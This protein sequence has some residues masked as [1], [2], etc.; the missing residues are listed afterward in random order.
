MK[1]E[2][3]NTFG[4]GLIMDLNPMTTPNNVLT[5]CL[6]GTVVTYNGNE[7]VL[8][9]DMG[10]GEVGTARL[11]VG[12][13]PVGM[14][15]HGGIIYVAAHNPVTGKSQIGS[16]PSP[17]QL[18]EGEDINVAAINIRFNE[19]IPVK[20]GVPYIEV[21]YY[22]RRLF[23][24]MTTGEP[25]KFHP[26]DK[27]I[28]VSDVLGSAL[29]NAINAGVVK[30]RLGVIN[31]SGVI[32]YIDDKALKTY[33]NGLWIYENSNTPMIDVLKS[34]ELVQVF[35]SKSSGALVLVIEIES[36][37]TFNLLRKYS[38]G[39][40]TK[41]IKVE[42][43]GEMT[44]H[45]EGKTTVD[46]NVKLYHD[47]VLKDSVLF[48]RPD[49][50]NEVVEY[51]VAPACPYG[52]L[53]RMTKSGVLDFAAIRSNKEIFGEWRFF[54]TETYVKIGWGY[55]Y[56][57]LNEDSDVEKVRF[58]FIDVNDSQHAY[59]AD[60][61]SGVWSYDIS[62]EYFNGSFEEIIPFSD[63]TIRKNWIYIVRIGKYVQGVYSIIG[64]RLLYT[65]GYF[66][67]IYETTADF[68]TL[69]ST[70]EALGIES[71]ITSE[72]TGQE[73]DA[74]FLRTNKDGQFVSKTNLRVDDY[75]T[76]VSGLDVDTTNYQYTT[77]KVGT[78]NVKIKPSMEIKYDKKMY[79][80]EPKS[81]ENAFNNAT[82]R[83]VTFDNSGIKYNSTSIL[84]SNISN[85]E[86]QAVDFK[87]DSAQQAIIGKLTTSRSI[88]ANAGGVKANPYSTET[89][90]PLY[91]TTMSSSERDQLF[92]FKED[93]G[94]TYC[95]GGDRGHIF[96]NTRVTGQAHTSG[97]FVGESAGSG[98]DDNGLQA[99]LLAMSNN[100]A[101]GIMAGV[102][103]D[104]ASLRI[105]AAR[106]S[107]NGWSCGD[108]EIDSEDNFMIATWKDT[109]GRHWL[110]NLASR[111]TESNSPDSNRLIRIEKMLK[112]F[113]SQ[114]L[115]VQRG[116]SET[117]FVGPNNLEF[118]YNMPFNTI[119]TTN[120]TPTISTGDRVVDFYLGND[121]T[122]ITTHLNKWKLALG[123]KFVN[124]APTF[125]V[126]IPASFPV[127][128]EYGDTVR[129]DSDSN[130]L[131][132][133]TNAY[134]F[135]SPTESPIDKN[136]IDR[137]RIYIGVTTGNANSDGTMNLDI[138][139]NTG[140]PK[141][142][143]DSYL[144]DWQGRQVSLGYNLNDR[145]ITKYRMEGKSDA[146]DENYFNTVYLRAD[147]LYTVANKWTHNKDR[148]APDMA[149]NIGFGH[150]STSYGKSLYRYS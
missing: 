31:T 50:S 4:D 62:K 121:S 146:I 143:S 10:N 49:S 99:A 13:V 150:P 138:D 88:F 16:F 84:N 131:S 12:Y 123:D 43:I 63:A 25:R 21:E 17:Q 142:H 104:E 83:N 125:R 126:N 23:E 86:S 98:Y 60:T 116:S 75:I 65:S 82:V 46:E 110:I 115:V 29:R 132:C 147:I 37:D 55:D 85:I 44:G 133:Y 141:T 95:A 73:D 78:Y 22:K 122:S 114:M 134:A 93:G 130:I 94:V 7:F 36:F 109:N 149:T 64:Y 101:I 107:V 26:G 135:K 71:N 81:L 67:E 54:V 19:L 33:S 117:F 105:G 48:E 28:I 128:I 127:K 140:L 111:K 41:Q 148:D 97:S 15:E 38:Y 3:I 102:N 18:Y 80:G 76:T 58:T 74:L 72:I 9:N 124:F 8:Q 5:N 145:F 92:S 34:N 108:N 57:N 53:E 66:N 69:T 90:A 42:L 6:N 137:G 32:D 144:T 79:A 47:D 59:S 113:L 119:A 106:D 2:A 129:I 20:N 27:F 91:R 11:P 77:K 118:V 1:K 30:L 56:Y 52:V 24:D 61:L 39:D 45:F 87:W 14:K 136:N 89:L 40:V 139:S 112:C 70:Q 100:A 120:V 68:T 96:Y 51:S 35:S 103:S